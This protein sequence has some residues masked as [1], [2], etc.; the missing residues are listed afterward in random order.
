MVQTTAMA[1]LMPVRAS[2][3]A[4]RRAD[5][6]CCEPAVEIGVHV[7][8]G[9]VAVV[10]YWEG[11]ARGE[12]CVHLHVRPPNAPRKVGIIFQGEKEFPPSSINTGAA[13]TT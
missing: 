4:A 13:G 10:A 1:A 12:I 5:V 7:E 3:V 6:G 2:R 11:V 9:E 8:E